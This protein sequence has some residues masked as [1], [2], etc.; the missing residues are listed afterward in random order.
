MALRVLTRLGHPCH[1]QSLKYFKGVFLRR[2]ICIEMFIQRY[3][4]E[5][6]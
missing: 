6:Q 3:Y 5:M 1:H 2:A 4:N